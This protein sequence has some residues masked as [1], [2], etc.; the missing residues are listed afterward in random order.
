MN[1]H[2]HEDRSHLADLFDQA[3]AQ[4][5]QLIPTGS[6]RIHRQLEVAAKRRDEPHGQIH[7]IGKFI[8]HSQA[9]ECDSI[10]SRIQRIRNQDRHD[11]NA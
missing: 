10:Q 11:G 1:R 3:T 5:L 2:W 6:L 7:G 9:F 4:F 8:G